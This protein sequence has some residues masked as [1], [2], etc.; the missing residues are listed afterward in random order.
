MEIKNR[1]GIINVS[2][3]VYDNNPEAVFALYKEVIPIHIE[4]NIAIKYYRITARSMKFD[5]LEEGKA[6]PEY[7]PIIE[8]KSKFSEIKIKEFRRLP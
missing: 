1:I 5:I 6:I 3:E 8:H 4:F 7:M 2:A